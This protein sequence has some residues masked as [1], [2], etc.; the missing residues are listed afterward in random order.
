MGKPYANTP[1][2]NI[3]TDLDKQM[4]T[5]RQGKIWEFRGKSPY[6]RD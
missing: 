3:A 1:S 2:R 4:L 5:P 6:G